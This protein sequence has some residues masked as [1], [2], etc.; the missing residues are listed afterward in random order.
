MFPQQPDP[1][2]QLPCTRADPEH[3][4][5]KPW[6]GQGRG[7]RTCWCTQ[8]CD[9][10][11]LSHHCLSPHLT[12]VRLWRS[13]CAMLGAQI[14]S[15]RGQIR[16]KVSRGHQFGVQSC[17]DAPSRFC[18]CWDHTSQQGSD[19]AGLLSPAVPSQRASK[20]F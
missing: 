5:L 13:R 2:L 15:L 12:K 6:E 19:V 20:M 16:F 7:C 9:S 18:R 8:G 11:L 10:H 1:K 3:L 17:V 14:L 4:Q